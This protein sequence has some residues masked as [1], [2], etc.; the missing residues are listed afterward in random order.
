MRLSLFLLSLGTTVFILNSTTDAQPA[1]SWGGMDAARARIEEYRKGD[2]TVIVRDRNGKPIPGARVEVDMKRHDFSFGSAINVPLSFTENGPKPEAEHY[3]EVFTENFNSAVTE[4]MMKYSGFINKDGSLNP[5]KLATAYQCVD[6]LDQQGILL[7]GHNVLW[8]SSEMSPKFLDGLPPEQLRGELYRRIDNAI[9]LFRGRLTD[10]D[11]VNEPAHHRTF[12]D[13]FGEEEVVYWYKRAHELEPSIPLYVNQYDVL[14]GHYHDKFKRWVKLLLDEGAPLGGIG[15]QG[16]VKTEQF[17][18]EESLE[19]VWDIINEYAAFGLPIKITE[20]DCEATNGED[21]QAQ[22]LEN[23]LTLFFSHPSMDGF[24][25]WGFWDG[26]HWRN[27][28]RFGLDKAGLWRE[29]WTAKPAAKA[30]HRLIFEDWWTN[31]S[32][33]TD[34]D[35]R[36][37]IRGF[38]GDYIVTVT[39]G[40]L[41][42]SVPTCIA[43]DGS[44]LTVTM[45]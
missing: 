38:S 20:F 43:Q 31:E 16:H 32:G 11:L 7:R 2:L 3:L 12:M 8:P 45:P 9:T 28:E 39:D 18:G 14:N 19:K 1:G 37:T 4:N 44:V 34:I 36:L 25:L 10:W 40:E 33:R 26:R 23:A 6:W 30:W 41:E 22:C 5:T 24:L 27:T 15:I 35:G 13:I 42:R 29:D 21:R 17:I